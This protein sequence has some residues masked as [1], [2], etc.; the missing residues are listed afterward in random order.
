METATHDSGNILD[1][2]ISSEDELV[3]DVEMCGK[4]G[5]SDQAMI[6]YQVNINATRSKNAKMSQL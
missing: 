3:S 2:I 6:K 5:K 4:V 1:L